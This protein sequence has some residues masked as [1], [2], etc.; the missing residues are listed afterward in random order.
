MT[1]IEEIMLYE[2]LCD[3]LG[4]ETMD[5]LIEL[6]EAMIDN[7]AQ[8]SGMDLAR[9]LDP[10]DDAF[11]V[12]DAMTLYRIVQESLNN[13]LKHSHARNVR[14]TL[15][16]DVREVSLQIE[17]DGVGFDVKRA[18]KTGLGLR[19]ISERARILGGELRIYSAPR[20]GTRLTLTVPTEDDKRFDAQ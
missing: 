19:N 17:D 4:K 1:A 8:S 20:Q 3:K 18:Q 14:I 6:F 10:I 7:A 11:P 16:R 5:C 13:I 12:G 15:E 9:K 2:K